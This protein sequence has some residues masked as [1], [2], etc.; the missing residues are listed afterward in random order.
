MVGIIALGSLVTSIVRE[1]KKLAHNRPA[2]LKLSQNEYAI[3]VL[4]VPAMP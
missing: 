4:P 1:Q 2:A 3:V